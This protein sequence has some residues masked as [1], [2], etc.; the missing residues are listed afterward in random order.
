MQN[1]TELYLWVDANTSGT[2]Q[3]V[4]LQALSEE[5]IDNYDCSM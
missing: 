4:V 3:Q 2:L 1:V 5:I